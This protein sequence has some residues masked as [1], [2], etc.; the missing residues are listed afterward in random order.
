MS[1]NHSIHLVLKIYPEERFKLG[2]DEIQ[3]LLAQSRIHADPESIVHHGVSVGQRARDAEVAA[4]HVGL[5]REVAGEQQAC[6]DLVLVKVLQ[7]IDAVDARA[8]LDGDGEA[9]PGWVAVRCSLR[10]QQELFAVLQA[11]LQVDKVRLARR[12]EF[13][14][15][16]HLRQRAGGLHIGDL[17][18]V[19]KVRIGVLVIVAMWQVAQLLAEALAAGVVLA[20]LAVAVPTPVTDRFDDLAQLVVVG[21]HCAAFA[22]GDVV[23]GV[24]AQCADVAEGANKAVD[25]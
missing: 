2:D 24:K 8:C 12:D 23:G 18:V 4:L 22:H 5:A 15:A 16:V 17:E 11:R 20:W 6:A 25:G 13:F 21:E 9:K 19:A 10:Q 3:H 1:P 7:Q 14:H